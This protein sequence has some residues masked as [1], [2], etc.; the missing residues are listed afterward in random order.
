M[1]NGKMMSVPSVTVTSVGEV[2]S[3]IAVNETVH[4]VNLQGS[5]K[6]STFTR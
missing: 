4:T 1:L 3:G 2:I 6:C 5:R